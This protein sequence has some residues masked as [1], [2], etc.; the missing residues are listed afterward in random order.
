MHG[1]VKALI[2]AAVA[3]QA[4]ANPVNKASAKNPAAQPP[5]HLFPAV[6]QV[7]TATATATGSSPAP[8]PTLPTFPFPG[9]NGT[10][11]ICSFPSSNSTTNS[12]ESATSTSSLSIKT[13]PVTSIATATSLSSTPISGTTTISTLSSYIPVPTPTEFTVVGLSTT[14][15]IE[16][17]AVPTGVRPHPPPPANVSSAPSVPF[18]TSTPGTVTS[19]PGTVTS[20]T[21]I[22]SFTYLPMVMDSCFAAHAF[23]DVH[24]GDSVISI[25][26]CLDWD[27][28]SA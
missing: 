11:Y 4:S 8:E 2:I 6:R 5:Y 14:A 3:S 1:T 10:Y 28:R 27:L 9:S 13:V 24:A 15:I 20:G 7:A 26:Q 22:P 25:I 12:T 16:C 18:P 23:N 21:L 19:A 17:I